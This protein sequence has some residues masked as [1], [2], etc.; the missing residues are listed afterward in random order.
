MTAVHTAL[1][2]RPLERRRLLM[3]ALLTPLLAGFYPAIFL[4]DPSIMPIGLVVAY[5]SVLLFGVPL[6]PLFDRRGWRQWWQFS[7]GGALCALPSILLYA[8]HQA[9]QHLQPFG[10]VPAAGLLLCGGVSGTSFW[11]VGVAGESPV[12]LRSLF[13]PLLPKK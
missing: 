9:P 11:L 2:A 3:A 10:I 4:A 1:R 5:A 7:A 12:T 6:V 13:D 8:L